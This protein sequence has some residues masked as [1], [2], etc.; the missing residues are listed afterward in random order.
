MTTHE[1]RLLE[2]AAFGLFLARPLGTVA[3][4]ILARVF[5]DDPRGVADGSGCTADMSSII[6][7]TI[8]FIDSK[9]AGER[10]TCTCFMPGPN[11]AVLV[12]MYMSAAA[13]YER[14]MS[15]RPLS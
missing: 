5:L 2:D 13:V 6:G 12:L 4:Y 7:W 15:C 1:R 14:G 11:L 8:A 9:V 3:G 10:L